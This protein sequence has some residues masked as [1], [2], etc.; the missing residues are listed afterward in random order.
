M[1]EGLLLYPEAGIIDQKTGEIYDMK[2]F[3]HAGNVLEPVVDH[4]L[5]ALEQRAW[6]RH[7]N[8]LTELLSALDES[9][10]IRALP[11]LRR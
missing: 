9:I 6:R 10:G 3:Q 1:A 4:V 2:H 11:A 5:V 8:L 7:I